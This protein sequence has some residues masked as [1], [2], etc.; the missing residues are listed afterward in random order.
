[1]IEVKL[2]AIV[3]IF[4]GFIL[5]LIN[6]LPFLS[7][8]H[9]RD[10]MMY[11]L[12][13]VSISISAFV[14]YSGQMTDIKE[15]YVPSGTAY[16]LLCGQE[17]SILHKAYVKINQLDRV[18]S[19]NGEITNWGMIDH[20]PNTSNYFSVTD[21]NVSD[22]LMGLGIKQYQYKFKFKKLDLRENLMDLYNVKYVITN[23]ATNKLSA[24]RSK[25][26]QKA[27]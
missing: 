19:I 4:T 25:Y 24:D 15:S 8:F 27:L 18:E 1:M 7:K 21:K 11:G 2:A 22:T 12:V 3:L 16:K 5:V 23:S 17:S 26:R 6:E 10:F 14:H 20:I 9:L 13:I